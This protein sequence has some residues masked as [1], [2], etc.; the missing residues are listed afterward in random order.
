MKYKC[1]KIINGGLIPN[2]VPK[3]LV[4][5]QYNCKI[6]GNRPGNIVPQPK[7]LVTENTSQNY[8]IILTSEEG[9]HIRA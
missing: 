5:N 6:C 7:Y 3:T 1:E 4:A 9:C 8:F 2:I